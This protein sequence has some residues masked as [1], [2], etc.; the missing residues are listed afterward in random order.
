MAFD[1]VNAIHCLFILSDILFV[2]ALSL[3]L[4]LLAKRRLFLAGLTAALAAFIR[5]IGLYY[6]GMLFFLLFLTWVRRKQDPS[7]RRLILFLLISF[8]PL[9]AWLERGWGWRASWRG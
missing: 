6:P 1:Y 3:L 8:L 4:L 7:W 5:P 9:A 2:F